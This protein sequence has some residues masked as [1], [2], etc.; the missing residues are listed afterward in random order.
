[1]ADDIIVNLPTHEQSTQLLNWLGAPA[2]GASDQAVANAHAKLNHMILAIRDQDALV[3]SQK[4]AYEHQVFHQSGNFTVPAGVKTVYVTMAGGGGGGGGA[5]QVGLHGGGGGGPGAVCYRV[6]VAVTPGTTVHVSV[7]TGGA[8]GGPGGNWPETGG[9]GAVGGSSAFLSVAIGGGIGGGG[10][11][12]GNQ[13]VDAKGGDPGKATSWL[14][15]V[16]RT[17][18]VSNI[19]DAFTFLHGFQGVTV[20][21]ANYATGSPSDPKGGDGGTYYSSIY[22]SGT[23]VDKFINI[24]SKFGVWD[25]GIGGKGGTVNLN[26]GVGNKGNDGFVVIEWG[27]I[28]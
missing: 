17:E 7:G 5:S 2:S 24:T 27:E 16:C 12:T 10:G 21:G 20:K 23:F 14:S 8:G 15:R 25:R 13:G 28:I 26:G 6:P 19:F 11:V 22:N 18:L 1:M 3:K 9:T 4:V